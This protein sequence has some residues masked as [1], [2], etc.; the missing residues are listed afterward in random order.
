MRSKS[1]LVSC[2]FSRVVNCDGE[3]VELC[4]SVECKVSAILGHLCPNINM[5]ILLTGLYISYDV[6]WEK[7]FKH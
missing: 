6:S 7:L 4:S 2:F 1:V 5:Q 3:E